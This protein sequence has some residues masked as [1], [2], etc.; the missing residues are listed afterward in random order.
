MITKEQ[1]IQDILS[2]LGRHLNESP[3]AIIMSQK[4]RDIVAS[5]I[6]NGDNI[7]YCFGIPLIIFDSNEYEWWL[8]WD[9]HQYRD[10]SV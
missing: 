3:K 4:L 1:V 9:R 10:I 2:E 7:R 5:D 8:S 6:I